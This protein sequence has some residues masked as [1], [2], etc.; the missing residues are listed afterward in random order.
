MMRHQPS[1]G[2]LAL[3]AGMVLIW[4]T[5]YWPTE[6]AAEHTTNV[7]LSGLR[8]MGGAVLIVA[9]ALVAR[10]RWPTGRVLLWGIGTGLVMVG[11]S[12][13]GTTEAVA[14]AGPGNA[15]VIVN[16]APLIIV[17][18]GW[19]FL[20]ERLSG[21]GLVG[22]VVGF[23][24][25]ILMVSSQ[26]GGSTDTTDFLL[27]VALAA[28]GA[29][30]WAA[31]TLVLRV[32]ATRRGDEIDMLSFTAVQFVAAGIVVL[33]AGFA[34]D[35]IGTTN[36]SSGELWAALFWIGP[37]SGLGFIFFFAALGK[38][39]A[40]RASAAMFLVPAVAVIVEIA[41][42]NIPTGLVVLGIV[43]A[44]L[45]VALV[46]A[47]RDELATLGPRLWRYVRTKAPS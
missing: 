3:L 47:P 41:R 44:V 21:I 7:V 34:V 17:A 4:G 18:L 5:G 26:L 39:S 30:A 23:G 28:A 10:A 40:A 38:I 22:I 33:A 2:P 46:N 16:S 12:H 29:I 11:I 1:Y 13:W 9:V 43:L 31:G 45:G 35:G 8:I 32:F 37:I 15:A 20:R 24:G 36:W 25:V 19:L 42:G 27:G 6:V 14:R